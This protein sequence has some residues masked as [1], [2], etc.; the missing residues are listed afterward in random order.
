MLPDLCSP[1][2]IC[3]NALQLVN[4]QR[5][6]QIHHV[7]FEAGLNDEVVFVAFIAETLPG[8]L[9]HAMQ[10]QHLYARQIFFHACQHHTAF[11]GGYVLGGIE[12]EAAKVAEGTGF[13]AVI[14][15]FDRVCAVLDYF[16]SMT[17]GDVGER[18]HVCRAPGEMHRQDSFRVWSDA[19]F[20][21]CGIDVHS[22]RIYVCKDRRRARVHDRVD[23]GAESHGSCDY[24]VTGA[25][26]G[27]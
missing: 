6:L 14:F 27:G 1:A 3:F 25:Y 5:R 8:V 22:P 21:F 10:S 15:R 12:T 19:G 26:P 16:Q 9:A 24:F 17:L 23:A 11:A 18:L 7:V 4:A 20:D 2:P 13:S